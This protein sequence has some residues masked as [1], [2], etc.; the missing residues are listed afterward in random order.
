MVVRGGDV[1]SSTSAWVYFFIYSSKILRSSFT[2]PPP[3][4]PTKWSGTRQH[5]VQNGCIFLSKNSTHGIKMALKL[6]TCLAHGENYPSK[7]EKVL[8]SLRQNHQVHFELNV[9]DL[10]EGPK[11]NVYYPKNTLGLFKCVLEL[12]FATINCL[13]EPSC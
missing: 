3:P 5:I 7:F 1:T 6:G 10:C 4:S 8:V 11:R 13:G 2:P 12:N 9:I